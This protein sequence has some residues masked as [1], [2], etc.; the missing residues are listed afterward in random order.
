IKYGL[1]LLGIVV[2]LLLSY[3]K[4]FE[5]FELQTLDLR[6]KLRPPLKVNP[7]IVIIEIADDSIN[8]LGRWPFDRGYHAVLIDCLRQVGARAVVFD[9]LF[10]DETAQDQELIEA[11]E[12]A[13]GLVYYPIAFR[14]DKKGIEAPLIDGLKA[15]AKGIGHINIAA[16][17]DGKIRRAPLF[18]EYKGKKYPQLAYRVALDY[19]G[20][21]SVKVPMAPDGTILINYAGKW[22][23]TFKHYSFVD[24]LRSYVQVVEGGKP[25]IDLSEF[26]NKVC[27]VGTTALGTFDVKPTPLEPAYPMVGVHANI[28]NSILQNKFLFRANK[29]INLAILITLFI[30]IAIIVNRVK[31][32]LGLCISLGIIFLFIIV[33]FLL[34]IIFGLWI[35]LF[36]PVVLAFGVY[37]GG[38]FNRYL[39]E[40]RNRLLLDKELSIAKKIQLNFLPQSV[41]QMEGIEIAASISTAKA[42]GGDL[43]DF[44]DL[45]QISLVGQR[46]LGIMIG[47]VSGKGVPAALFMARSIAD[48]RHYVSAKIFPSSVLTDLN[49]QI[50]LNYK[51]D[52]FI[53]MFYMIYDGLKKQLTFSNGGHLP[54]IWLKAE[55]TIELVTTEGMPLGLLDS[56]KYSDATVQLK[57]GDMVILYTDGITEA[58]N[59]NK[60]EFTIERVKEVVLKNRYV[61]SQAMIDVIK[62]QLSK[63]VGTAPQY[64]DY[65]IVIIKV[66]E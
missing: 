18:I 24:M 2:L 52:L 53:T 61:S 27:F 44:A 41:P 11:T 40:Q 50:A 33:G 21:K 12:K 35:D 47:D 17:I 45:A 51:S 22:T 29:I 49:T 20:G 65:T 25:V 34:F 26:Y 6:F 14:L 66:K 8:E 38:T 30:V 58:R 62:S 7:D 57:D 16:D 43:Y 19:F 15:N 13:K 31:P 56:E 39:V 23:R 10:S 32:L 4:V 9:I 5:N 60:E 55:G 48:F 54:A 46:K 28:L 36:Y 3:F 59:Q 1:Y 37:L 64:D 63:F 42:V